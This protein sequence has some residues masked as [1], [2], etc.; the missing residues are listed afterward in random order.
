MPIQM[1]PDEII[2]QIAAGEVVERPAHLVKELCE[3]ALDAGASEVEVEVSNGGRNIV[4]RD[5]GNGIPE[6]EM[7]L[8]LQ[9]HTTSKLSKLEDIWD[10]HSFGFRGEALASIASISDL[11]LLSRTPAQ[12]IGSRIRSRFGKLES[13]IKQG[14]ERGTTVAVDNLFENVPARLKFLKSPN[15]EVSQIRA[16]IK[17]L[18]LS[19]PSVQWR[20]LIEGK[21]DQYY[22]SSTPLERVSQVFENLKVFYG[23]SELSDYSVEVWFVDPH[24]TVKTNKNIWI[25]V[26][27]RWVQD[28]SL[29]AAVMEGYRNILMHHEY[30]Q[31]V[32]SVKV[33]PHL[34]DVNIHPTKSQ[35]K[36]ENP[37][38]AFRAIVHAIRDGLEK[39]EWVKSV[40][41]RLASDRSELDRSEPRGSLS[42]YRP[43]EPRQ[44]EVA[45]PEFQQTHFRKRNFD[46]VI[47]S[48]KN[49]RLRE[50]DFVP[51]SMKDWNA[52]KENRSRQFSELVASDSEVDRQPESISAAPAQSYWQNLQIIG[53]AGLK[54]IICQDSDGLVVI[55][56]HAADERVRF[57]KI[58]REI[59]NRSFNWQDLLFPI[60]IDM[61]A[62]KKE[63]LILNSE[64]LVNLGIKIEEVGPS[65]LSV[66][67]HADWV[68]DSK[69]PELLLKMSDQILELG[70][71]FVVEKYYDDWIASQACH[72][73]IRAGKALS[74]VE[75][76]LL[77]EEMDLFPLSSFCPH[78]RPVSIKKSFSDLDKDF[79]RIV[80]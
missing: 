17:A 26:Q 9:R 80:T 2:N 72:G 63:A 58:K 20:F 67:S 50:L 42:P 33:P 23:C 57:E 45:S 12:E 4:V 43:M 69:I 30:P 73:S 22:R 11:T 77:L 44:L 6:E 59:L 65:S 55:D 35:V 19:N 64:K 28:R 62:E 13:V 78:G 74:H 75:I 37:S 7:A 70:D 18:A 53:Q 66:V 39:A 31:V 56:Q 68:A 48:A 79:G 5:N 1:L 51:P 15:V 46:A 25:F 47:S 21:L 71:S 29:M 54:Y 49:D 61:S 27:G 32:I 3:N 16:V 60:L 52:I 14:A 34:V 40:P 76:K 36:F 41:D 38:T 8:A 10:L 24:E